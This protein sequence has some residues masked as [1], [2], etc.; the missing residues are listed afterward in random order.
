M[1]DNFFPEWNLRYTKVERLVVG[2]DD[3]EKTF[4]AE[5]SLFFMIVMGMMYG[6]LAIAFRSYAQPLLIM[7]AI[8]FAFVGMVFGS[9]LMDVPLG[10]MSIFGFFAA[11]GVA[12][13]DNLVLIDYINRLR[14]KGVGAYQSVVDACVSR[15]RPILLTSVTTFVG[16]M[17]MLSEKS[18][19]AQFLKP[20]VV[21]LAFGVLFDFFPH[22][23]VGSCYVRNRHRH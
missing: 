19:Q 20:L 3:L 10:M 12:V 21:A 15:F 5:L 23:Y 6:L 22:S 1:K 14:D 18:V 8:P 9:M 17:P 2:D 16:I 4:K 11:A 13:N 7:I